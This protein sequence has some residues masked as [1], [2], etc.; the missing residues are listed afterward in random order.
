MRDSYKEIQTKEDHYYTS[1][2]QH[3]TILNLLLGLPCELHKKSIIDKITS[4][5]N[6]LQPTVTER[7]SS[8]KSIS[9][10]G[11]GKKSKNSPTKKEKASAAVSKNTLCIKGEL[12]FKGRILIDFHP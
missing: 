9:T 10:K 4:F 5:K 8:P 11:K 2:P 6:T 7:I 12:L 1:Y 3:G